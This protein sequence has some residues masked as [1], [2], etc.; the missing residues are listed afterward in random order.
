MENAPPRAA[1][2]RIGGVLKTGFAWEYHSTPAEGRVWRKA[3]STEN[4]EHTKP[5]KGGVRSA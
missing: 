5:G 4:T 2:C 3:F 1:P